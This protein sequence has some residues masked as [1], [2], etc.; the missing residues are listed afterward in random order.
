MMWCC[1]EC[2]VYKYVDVICVTHALHIWDDIARVVAFVHI[3]LK[4]NGVEQIK[5]INQKDRQQ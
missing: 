2:G 1:A 5:S 3:N 4:K